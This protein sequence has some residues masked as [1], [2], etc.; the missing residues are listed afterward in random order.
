MNEENFF[1]KVSRSSILW[2]T[3]SAKGF[4]LVELLVVIAIIGILAAVVLVSLS[5]SRDKARASAAL[6]T[7][8]SV[9]PII[10]GCSMKGDTITAPTASGGAA[11]CQS[12]NWPAVGTGSTLNCSYT[13]N[14]TGGRF[15]IVCTGS[16]I[17]CDYTTNNNCTQT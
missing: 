11:A 13:T 9:L 7:G 5:S 16:T 1:R 12:V 8:R 15:Q 2:P 3:K 4:T 6:Q 10:L 17:S 14:L